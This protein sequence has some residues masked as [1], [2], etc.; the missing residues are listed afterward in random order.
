MRLGLHSSGKSRFRS[1]DHDFRFHNLTQN[2]TRVTGMTGVTRVNWMTKM[3]GMT[4]LAWITKMNRMT[5]ISWM[6]RMTGMT[7]SS[8]KKP[9]KDLMLC[10]IWKICVPLQK[11]SAKCSSL[12]QV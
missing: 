8:M 10:G 9:E 11:F 3:S 6:G 12:I 7:S 4:E 2:L 1:W 5:G